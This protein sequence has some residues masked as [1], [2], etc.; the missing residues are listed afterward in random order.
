MS[1][2][3]KAATLPEVKASAAAK[4]SSKAKAQTSSSKKRP[5]APESLDTT[6]AKAA[7]VSQTGQSQS[8]PSADLATMLNALAILATG[9][10]KAQADETMAMPDEA[11]KQTFQQLLDY[12]KPLVLAGQQRLPLGGNKAVLLVN[13]K[14]LRVT[15]TEPKPDADDVATLMPTDHLAS[16][17]Q[18]ALIIA[19][20][21][22]NGLL[23]AVPENA[24]DSFL[25]S[26]DIKEIFYL[27]HWFNY[28]DVSSQAP[29]AKLVHNIVQATLVNCRPIVFMGRALAKTPITKDQVANDSELRDLLNKM[30]AVWYPLG[31]GFDI[32]ASQMRGCVSQLNYLLGIP[33]SDD[34]KLADQYASSRHGCTDALLVIMAKAADL[35]RFQRLCAQQIMTALACEFKEHMAKGHPAHSWPSYSD[36]ECMAQWTR[37]QHIKGLAKGLG[38]SPPNV[39]E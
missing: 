15:L 25:R 16:R 23:S 3:G 30:H 13:S 36:G 9:D 37:L 29:C 35:S 24:L 39:L 27:W 20:A 6:P 33:N 21:S 1:T 11:I 10:S 5:A 32:K 12:D 14:L 4:G 18:T 31:L 34:H 7:K 19:W 38:V 8:S 22:I 26:L 28:L 2:A 17:Q